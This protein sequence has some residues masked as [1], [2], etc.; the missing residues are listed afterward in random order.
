MTTQEIIARAVAQE[1]CRINYA[2]EAALRAAA[3]A[4]DSAR[5]REE[6]RNEDHQPDAR[7]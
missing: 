2:P 6:T 1:L 7:D 5:T 3:Q 4:A